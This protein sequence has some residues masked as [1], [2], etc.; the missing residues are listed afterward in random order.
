MS[1]QVSTS[2]IPPS[3]IEHTL[4]R[5]NITVDQLIAHCE[6]ALLLKVRSVCVPPYFVKKAKN[7]VGDNCLVVTVVGYP[8]GQSCVASKVEE[9]KRAIDDGADEMDAV[10]NFSAAINADWGYLDN[11]MDSI[12]RAT[13]MRGK[14][15][16]L[17]VEPE[18]IGD[19]ALAHVIQ[20]LSDFGIPYLKTHTGMTPYHATPDQVI[21]IRKL[22]APSIHIKASGGIRSVEVAE[23]LLVAGAHLLGT[24]SADKLLG[25]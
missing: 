22:L 25:Q 6:T 14:K 3:R 11:E 15:L 7:I 8:S 19:I 9:V 17:I 4:L 21:K 13:A 1:Q 24:S 16:K 10:I 23:Q 5:P 2:P 12:G 20:R 18:M